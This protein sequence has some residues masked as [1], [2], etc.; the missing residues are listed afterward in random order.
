M[1]ENKIKTKPAAQ[2]QNNGDEIGLMEKLIVLI[3]SGLMDILEIIGG[4]AALSVVGALITVPIDILGWLV[5]G[6]I[7]IWSFFR[8]GWQGIVANL[9]G[10]LAD[11]LTAGILPGRT[12]GAAISIKIRNI[13]KKKITEKI[14]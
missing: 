8:T 10:L 5:S 14:T 7:F 12:I 9:I 6:G 4:I 11:A 13:I 3:A 2:E 1:A